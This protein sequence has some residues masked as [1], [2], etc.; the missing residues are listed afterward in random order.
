[1]LAVVVVIAT[2]GFARLDMYN[3]DFGGHLDGSNG[4]EGSTARQNYS[5]K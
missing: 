4:V 2:K 1:M 5:A 3:L